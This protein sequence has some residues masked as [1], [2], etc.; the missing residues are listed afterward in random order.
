KAAVPLAIR[1]WVPA[2]VI[3]VAIRG[4]LQSSFDTNLA[5][6]LAVML[7]TGSVALAGWRWVAFKLR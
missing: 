2:A 4:A 1:S 7:A 6:F 3:G 5:I